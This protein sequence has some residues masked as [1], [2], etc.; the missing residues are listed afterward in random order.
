[1]E[2]S[3]GSQLKTACGEVCQVLPGLVDGDDLRMVG[4][5]GRVSTWGPRETWVCSEASTQWRTRLPLTGLQVKRHALG[6]KTVK[7]KC[8]NKLQK[9]LDLSTSRA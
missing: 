2:I 7:A 1:M 8:T 4:Q 9:R 6:D 5:Q 3:K